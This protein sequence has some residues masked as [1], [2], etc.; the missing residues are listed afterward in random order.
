MTISQEP[1]GSPF[2]PAST[3]SEVIAG[4]DLTGR[5]ALVT[6]GNSGLGLETARTLAG[7]GAHVIIADRELDAARAELGPSDA[8]FVR[9]DLT[10]P[11]TIDDLCA[12]V[13]G[14]ELPLHILINA[15]GI[16]APPLSRDSRGNERQLSTNHLGHFQLTAG[17][18]PALSRAG[19]ARVVLYSSLAHQY[20]PVDF[21][22]PNYDRR[23]Y[24][25][26]QAYGQSKTAVA[27]FAVE[28][29]QRAAAHGV[30]AFAVHP[31]N[32]AS[33]GLGTYLKREDMIAAGLLDADGNPVVDPERRLKTPSQG[34]ATGV[35]CAT[36]IQLADRG[37]VYCEDC[38]IATLVSSDAP[39]DFFESGAGRGV[40]RYAV[41]TVNAARNWALSEELTGVRFLS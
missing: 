26:L 21:D 35:W 19:G 25:P 15:A 38:D 10:D 6:G 18:W 23:E 1:I 16:M 5:N 20:A 32:I 8:E 39:L 33:T 12:S 31:G 3:S 30:R 2:G 34:A 28:L 11:K 4:I 9:V 22:D 14:R 36:S 40:M 24:D 27:L 37:G 17:L 7:A 13:T 29:D 41:D